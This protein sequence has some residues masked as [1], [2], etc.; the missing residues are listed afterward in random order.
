MYDVIMHEWFNFQHEATTQ[1]GTHN[2]EKHTHCAAVQDDF[3][4]WHTDN[5]ESEHSGKLLLVDTSLAK[6]DPNSTK[7]QII[8]V[9]KCC[10]SA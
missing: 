3:H 1:K 7:E 9:K 10:I 8:Q 4:W 5:D 2:H 6:L